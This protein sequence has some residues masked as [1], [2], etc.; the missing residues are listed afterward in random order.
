MPNREITVRPLA[1]LLMAT[2]L[3]AG[4]LA[5]VPALAQSAAA[6]SGAVSFSQDQIEAFVQVALRVAEIRENYAEAL[7]TA[8]TE[9]EQDRLIREGN[10]AMLAAVEDAGQ[11][12]IEDYVTIGEAAAANPELGQRIL[13][14]MEEHASAGG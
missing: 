9:E 5:P 7:E 12:T 8:E 11:I 10:S 6:E 4:T 13:M 14:L 2:G 1:A 3:A